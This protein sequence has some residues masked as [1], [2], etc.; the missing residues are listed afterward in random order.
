MALLAMQPENTILVRVRYKKD[1]GYIGDTSAFGLIGPS[2]CGAFSVWVGAADG[3]ARLRHPIPINSDLKM[4]DTGGYY[5]CSYLASQIPL[6]QTMR[7]D[8]VV[9]GDN[10]VGPWI[11]GDAAQPPPGQ[12]RII[13]NGSREATLNAIQSRA[14]L[15]FEMAYAPIVQR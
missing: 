13:L 12:H 2:S 5:L 1:F 6:D 8:V 3:S 10:A 15:S 9:S 7:V 4:E 14:R 11:R